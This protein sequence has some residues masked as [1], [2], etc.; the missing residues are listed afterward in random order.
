M[1][2]MNYIIL[3]DSKE[4]ADDLSRKIYLD[5]VERAGLSPDP[6]TTGMFG[7][8][9]NI[10]SG[11]S[12]LCVPLS[13]WESLPSK[14]KTNYIRRTPFWIHERF[15]NGEPSFVIGQ[16]PF[17]LGLSYVDPKET[18]K[19]LEGNFSKPLITEVRESTRKYEASVKF[20]A[21]RFIHE[22]AAN[23]ATR[24]KLLTTLDPHVFEEVVAELLADKGFEVFLTSRTR[25]NGK[26][27][28]AA[29]PTE[30]GF[31]LMMI[32]CKRLQLEKTLGPGDIRALYGQYMLDRQS[33]SPVRCAMLA[34]TAQKIGTVGQ[35]I[36]EE[37]TDITVKTFDDL[38]EWISSYGRSKSGLWV[39]EQFKEVF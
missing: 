24:A 35:K 7:T 1:N 31:I 33:G 32:D 30:E 25:D 2:G 38:S 21:E 34:T 19:I 17:G 14:F 26:D 8:Y 37:N 29:Y 39:P 16:G 6:N 10:L 11:Q 20:R 22:V 9:E 12:G 15:L 3:T 13:Y 36:I 4:H 5:N 18:R 27:I 28:Y 23:P